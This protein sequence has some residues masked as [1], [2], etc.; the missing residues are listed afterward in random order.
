[1]GKKKFLYEVSTRDSMV[2]QL[3]TRVIELNQEIARQKLQIAEK[4]GEN[5]ALRELQDKQDR[6]INRLQQEIEKL[7]NQ[8]LSQ[9]QLMDISLKKKQEELATKEKV[10]ENMQLTIEKQEKNL[11]DVLT[12]LQEALRQYDPKELS[13]EFRDGKAY[14]GLSE[15]LLFKTGSDQLGR[16]ASGVLE[17][18]AG[19]LVNHPEFNIEV[20][21]HTDNVPVRSK[22]FNNNWDLSVMRAASVVKVLTKDFSL[23]PSQVTASGRGEYLPKASNETSEGRA[24]NRRMEIILSLRL[25]EVYQLIRNN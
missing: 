3:N 16:E 9:Q 22:E 4:T 23:N 20:E 6:Q 7:T 18:V 15:K 17:S 5:N 21:G 24:Q 13:F 19:V 8:S 11:K 10:I 25:D 14:I 12:I 2:T 1:V